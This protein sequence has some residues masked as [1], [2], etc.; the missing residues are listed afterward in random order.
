[1]DF[2]VSQKNGTTFVYVLPVSPNSALVEY[3]LFTSKLLEKQEYDEAL[4]NY[5]SSYLNI[6][7]YTI[8]EEEFGVI[9]MTNMKFV[10]RLGKVINIGTAGGQTKA[11]SGYTFQFIQK[12][13]EQ[14]VLDLL[15]HGY[16]KDHE[17]FMDKRFKFYD[18]TLLN[19]LHNNR[20]PGD[21]IFADLFQKNPTSRVLKFLDN[22]STLEDEINLMG[23]LPQG[24]FIKAALAEIFK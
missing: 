8:V 24:V 16:P 14:L 10:K 5:I 6:A 1:M 11:S 3:T 23:T 7:E 19:I 4:R 15:Q 13:S 20:H 12:Q 21:K 9:P 2:R 22:E 18:T 17:T